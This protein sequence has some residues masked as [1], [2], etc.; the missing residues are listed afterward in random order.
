MIGPWTTRLH[1]SV[2][3]ITFSEGGSGSMALIEWCLVSLIRSTLR[4]AD[5][6][7]SHTHHTHPHTAVGAGVFRLGSHT[8]ATQVVHRSSKGFHLRCCTG[9]ADHKELA[10]SYIRPFFI[11]FFFV[12]NSDGLQP[13]ICN[14]LPTITLQKF[15]CIPLPLRRL[16]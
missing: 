12:S 3:H 4:V 13:T 1:P 2:E 10:L 9:S 5:S 16:K 8:G 7:A 11:V 14:V 15:V 6:G